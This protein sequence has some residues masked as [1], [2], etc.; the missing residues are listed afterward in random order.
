MVL[1][2]PLDLPSG[3]DQEFSGELTYSP[4]AETDPETCPADV[5]SRLQS[6]PEETDGPRAK[7]EDEPTDECVNPS[8]ESPEIPPGS[9]SLVPLPRRGT[10]SRK[11]PERYT[12]V[13]RLQVRP[14]TLA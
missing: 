14:A 6:T 8:P 5:S 11:Q 1:E 2:T 7:P 13:Q 3:P 10:R 4:D 9:R 12:P